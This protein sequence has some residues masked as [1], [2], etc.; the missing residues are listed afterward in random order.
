MFLD[1]KF[2]RLLTRL[3][4]RNKALDRWLGSKTIGL[5]GISLVKKS[6]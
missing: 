2:E 1:V 4:V 5:G 6:R 3:L